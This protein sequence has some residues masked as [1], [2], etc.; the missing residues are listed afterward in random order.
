MEQNTATAMPVMDSGKQS[1]GK[2]WKIAT[3]IASVVA[4]CGIGFG[5]YSMMQGSQKDNQ[6]SNLKAQLENNNLSTI[7]AKTQD[8]EITTKDENSEDYYYFG[9]LGVKIR[10]EDRSEF[11][12]SYE[13]SSNFVQNRDNFA[14]YDANSINNSSN[15]YSVHPYIILDEIDSCDHLDTS[16]IECLEIGDKRITVSDDGNG[17]SISEEFRKWVT[18][19]ENYSEI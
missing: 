2:G 3:A 14:I 7:A 12:I 6:I 10:K 15:N 5:V 1:D 17:G 11:V 13:Y 19:V 8:D 4:V 9:Q 18:N 16:V